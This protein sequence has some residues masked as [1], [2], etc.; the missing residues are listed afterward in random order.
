MLIKDYQYLPTN[1]TSLKLLGQSAQ[2][3]CDTKCGRPAWPFTYWPRSCTHQGLSV[4][5][6][7]YYTRFK[8]YGAKC[9]WFTRY[10]KCG[11]PTWPLTY[12]PEYAIYMYQIWSFWVKAFSSYLVHK[13]LET[14]MTFDLL[15]WIRTVII[16]SCG[17]HHL[18]PWPLTYWPEYEQWSYGTHHLLP[19]PLTYWPEYEQWSYGTHHLLP[20]PLTYWPEYEQWS[21]GTHHLLPWL[22][23]SLP[24]CSP[25]ACLPLRGQ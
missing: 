5:T 8:A 14:N 13:V 25:L 6:C 3:T 10:T 16:V 21:Y 7:T 18:L 19:W 12:W 17:T 24:L 23:L 1:V 15:T 4:S 22:W 2:V 11:R 9:S 20:W